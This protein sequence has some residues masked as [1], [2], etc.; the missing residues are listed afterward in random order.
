AKPIMWHG[1]RCT[2]AASQCDDGLR[3]RS[4]DARVMSYHRHFVIVVAAR[5]GLSAQAAQ[6]GATRLA[7]V[8]RRRCAPLNFDPFKIR[9]VLRFFTNTRDKTAHDPHR[10]IGLIV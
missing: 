1:R 9:E 7:P 4:T 10:T 8:R 2:P 3:R 6:R 5:M